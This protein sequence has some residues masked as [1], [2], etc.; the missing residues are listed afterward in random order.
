MAERD[1]SGIAG[2]QHQRDRADG[3]EQHLVGEVEREAAG[4]R[5]Q[6]QRGEQEE[7][8]EDLPGPG[9]DQPQVLRIRGAEVAARPR[10]GHAVRPV[11]Q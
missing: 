11:G 6:Q 9:I 3:R 5:R 2:Q 7:R 8:E 1:L 10:L 4:E